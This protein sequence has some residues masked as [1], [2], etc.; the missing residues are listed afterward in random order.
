MGGASSRVERDMQLEGEGEKERERER[1]QIRFLPLAGHSA[2]R[3]WLVAACS[4]TVH[5][6]GHDED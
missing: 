6:P 5:P 4:G 1:D 2:E 3:T